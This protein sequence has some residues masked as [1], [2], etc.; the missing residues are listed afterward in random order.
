M[1][2][3]GSKFKYIGFSLLGGCVGTIAYLYWF[4]SKEEL[5]EISRSSEDF[6]RVKGNVYERKKRRL[7]DFDQMDLYEDCCD[8]N[9]FQLIEKK[10]N[11]YLIEEL[12]V[13][14]FGTPLTFKLYPVSN[15]YGHELIR[16]YDF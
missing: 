9:P 16:Y 13:I 11:D 8:R 14:L 12:N 6:I 5:I 2:G 4:F 15:V 3:K 10:R 7:L 1:T